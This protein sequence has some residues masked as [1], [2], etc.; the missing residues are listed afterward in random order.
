MHVLWPK[1]RFWSKIWD[2]L[3]L[4]RVRRNRNQ[5]VD[6]YLIEFKWRLPAFM[7]ISGKSLKQNNQE[8]DKS[9]LLLTKENK[10]FAFAY[11]I[12]FFGYFIIFYSFTPI[13]STRNAYFPLS[14]HY[15]C[16]VFLSYEQRMINYGSITKSFFTSVSKARNLW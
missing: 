4:P 1:I 5:L 6:I 2:R 11:L 14:L 13:I 10:N 16:K 7:K 9:I 8:S 12:K 3:Q 15:L